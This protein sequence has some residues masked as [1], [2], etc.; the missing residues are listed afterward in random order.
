LPEPFDAEAAEI[1]G[2]CGFV[3]RHFTA[4][5]VFDI[6]THLL[7]GFASDRLLPLHMPGV[8]VAVRALLR[9]RGHEEFRFDAQIVHDLLAGAATCPSSV[10]DDAIS[11]FELLLSLRLFSVLS[12][13]VTQSADLGESLFASLI[14][15]VLRVDRGGPQLL[16][17]LADAFQN[18]DRE[19]TL[20]FAERALPLL[21][22]CSDDIPDHTW[23]KLLIGVSRGG[24]LFATLIGRTEALALADFAR[25]VADDR[26]LSLPLV[27]NALPQA[28]A[29]FGAQLALALARFSPQMAAGFLGFAAAQLRGGRITPEAWEALVAV[30]QAV[31]FERWAPAAEALSQLFVL[32]LR[33][34]AGASRCC[35][36]F[37]GQ[38][39]ESARDECWRRLLRAAKPA[40][41]E[42]AE[43]LATLVS[44]CGV[45]TLALADALPEIAVRAESE[46]IAHFLAA[47]GGKIGAG[48]GKAGAEL[49][50]AVLGAEAFAEK[51]AAFLRAF[52]GMVE[53]GKCAQQATALIEAVIGPL[54]PETTAAVI[55]I[56]G[57]MPAQRGDDFARTVDTLVRLLE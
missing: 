41:E 31:E 19:T 10:L 21:A 38:A 8:I 1:V 9:E 3:S 28:P 4:S 33:T 14:A 26:P 36:V 32:A 40:F 46:P 53:A 44:A 30:L 27:L 24:A 13:F 50:A 18:D 42:W 23:T 6:V 45:S 37:L 25:I 54:A 52:A 15:A 39:G 35:A 11:I 56:V 7:A 5:Q 57:Q 17:V 47:V 12:L 51:R 34:D 29:A 48:E 20:A 2:V 16:T 43:P 49:A 55:V 22:R